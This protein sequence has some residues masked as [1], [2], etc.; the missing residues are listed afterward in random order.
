MVAGFAHHPRRRH[1][2]HHQQQIAGRVAADDDMP[3]L[4]PP[5]IT[6]IR[7][8]EAGSRRGIGEQAQTIC[9]IFVNIRI[10]V[11]AEFIR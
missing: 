8:R 7:I 6:I 9:V 11:S 5:T 1:H 2:H 4:M 10:S 3:A